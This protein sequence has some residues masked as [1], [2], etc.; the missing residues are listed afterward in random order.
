MFH[1]LSIMKFS[2]VRIYVYAAPIGK[3]P[4]L[5]YEYDR[6]LKREPRPVSFKARR[7]TREKANHRVAHTL[8]MPASPRFWLLGWRLENL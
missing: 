1:C 6:E 4:R 7:M 3:S 8:S 2:S 5:T